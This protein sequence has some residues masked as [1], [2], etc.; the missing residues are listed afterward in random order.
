M[1]TITFSQTAT[2][3]ILKKH[4][5]DFCANFIYKFSI[6][7]L[8]TFRLRVYNVNFFDKNHELTTEKAKA[9]VAVIYYDV[10]NTTV[11][12]QTISKDDLLFNHLV[13]RFYVH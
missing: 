5:S 13:R 10:Q 1:N 2:R 12:Q 6:R 7:E 4:L 8:N 9:R 3:V 11:I